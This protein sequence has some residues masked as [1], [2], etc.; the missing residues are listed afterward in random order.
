MPSKECDSIKPQSVSGIVCSTKMA[1]KL[2]NA[3]NVVDASI[4]ELNS[5]AAYAQKAV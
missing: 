3:F 2:A 4:D 1:K 5:H